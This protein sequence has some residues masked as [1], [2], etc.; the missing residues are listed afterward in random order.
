MN[1]SLDRSSMDA[2]FTEVGGASPRHQAQFRSTMNLRRHV[3]WDTSAYYVGAL[4]SGPVPGHVRLDTRL[5]WRLGESVEFSI[6][7]QNL[8]APGRIEFVNSFLVHSTEA[9]R[10]IT[11]KVTWLF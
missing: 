3:E 7:G 1:L 8:L 4:L 11:A 10:S 9:Q 6:A 2:A 5:G